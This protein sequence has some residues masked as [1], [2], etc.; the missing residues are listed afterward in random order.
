MKIRLANAQDVVALPDLEKRAGE[1][2]RET[3]LDEIADGD[4][5]SEAEYTDIQAQGLLWVAV[6]GTAR[7]GAFLAGKIIDGCAY[8][9]EVSVDPSQQGKGL[10]RSLIEHFCAWAKSRG[11]PLVTLSTFRSVPWNGPYYAKLGFKE[12]AGADLGP[13]HLA[14]RRD[15]VENGLDANDRIFMSRRP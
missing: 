5:T 2:F 11:Y 15:E 4:P 14:V 9:H 10:G 7:P 3:G 6:E 1:L 12:V 8:I 13:N